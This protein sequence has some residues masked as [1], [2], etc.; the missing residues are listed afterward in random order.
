MEIK[1]IW[2]GQGK[3]IQN[4]SV[5]RG[6]EGGRGVVIAAVDSGGVEEICMF[7]H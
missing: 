3:R 2:I 4:P 6:V 1:S 5:G 7:R